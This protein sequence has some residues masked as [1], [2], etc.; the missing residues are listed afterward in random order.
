[1]KVPATVGF[2]LQQLGIKKARP[3]PHSSKPC[4][5]Q[6]SV[7]GKGAGNACPPNVKVDENVYTVGVLGFGTVRSN[8]RIQSGWQKEGCSTGFAVGSRITTPPGCIA[9]MVRGRE[10]Q[11]AGKVVRK[12]MA[13]SEVSFI[14]IFPQIKK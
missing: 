4:G 14:L 8:S 5:V 6:V 1:V 2:P 10:S 7:T 13:A 9:S 11:T 3:T 12:K